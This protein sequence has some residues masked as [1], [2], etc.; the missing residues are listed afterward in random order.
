MNPATVPTPE[1]NQER[2][3]RPHPSAWEHYKRGLARLIWGA[4]V[5]AYA[6]V[7]FA[8]AWPQDF[9][10]NA[11]AY[12]R[13]ATAAFMVRTFLFHLGLAL[14]LGAL[15]AGVLRRCWL[16]GATIPL[17]VFAV[18]PELWSYLPR[19][20]A[21]VT[22]EKLT[23]MSVNL[24]AQ[25]KLT[26]PIVAEV[27]A[28]KPDVLL[29]QEYA[30]HWHQAFQPAL[31]AQY[32]HV[33]YVARRD[34]FGLAI[35]S[36]RPFVDPVDMGIRLGMGGTPQARAVLWLDGRE[37]VF[38]N[39]HLVPPSQHAWTVEHR[40]EF[41]DLLARVEHEKLPIV[42]CGDFNFTNASVFADRLERLGLTD[43]HRISG[44]GRGATWPRRGPFRW[45]PGLRLDH[46]FI[47][48]ELT[49]TRS[50]T[51]IGRGSDHRSVIADIGF[52][53]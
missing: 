13:A 15:V 37:V 44:R 30:P 4:V 48:K 41:A 14:T 47:S 52:A 6:A 50:R 1:Q 28:A 53:H 35:Y 29:L 3:Q 10:N 2:R 36:R 11:P 45:F 46:L 49:S 33:Q 42:L 17:I 20:T 27:V 8:Y 38:Y 9:R 25:N 34:S 32:P 51:G 22:G 26:D 40:R 24:L 21:I 19:R 39:V 23:V 31:S 16:L 43:A 5:L 18:G 12:V 7:I